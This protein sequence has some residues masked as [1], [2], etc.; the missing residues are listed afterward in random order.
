ML[1]VPRRSRR[2]RT[3]HA[4]SLRDVVLRDGRRDEERSPDD[5]ITIEERRIGLRLVLLAGAA[6]AVA[7]ALHF[8]APEPLV[9]PV[10]PR[11]TRAERAAPG[12]HPPTA[13]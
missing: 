4:P 13:R 5:R 2:D 3:S 1:N 7:V 8:L 10:D 12:P 9:P 11:L 6:V